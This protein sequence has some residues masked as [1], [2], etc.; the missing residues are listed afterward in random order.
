MARIENPSWFT[1]KQ[2]EPHLF[3]TTENHFFEGNRS[4]I[5]LIRGVA[6]D[7]IID[8]GLGVCNLKKHLENLQL[9]S[10]DRECIVLCTHSHFDHSGGANHFENESKVLIH[11]YDYDGLRNGRQ[12]ETL[13]YVKPTHFSQQPYQHFSTWQY[14]VPSTKCEPILDGHR[15]DL[16]AGDEVTVLH[17]PGHTRGSIVCYYPKE[18]SLFTG[19]FVYD[20]GHGGNLFDWLPTSSVQEY[21]RSANRMLDWLQEHDID[22]I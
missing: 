10:K 3:L 21:L 14:E 8:C 18:K 19:D 13:N 1:T 16:G 7:L 11:Q 4:N 20:C 22:K 2:I 12:V 5:W 15:I 9:L 17:V 6:R